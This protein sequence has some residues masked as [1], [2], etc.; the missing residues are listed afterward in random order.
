MN[1][2]TTKADGGIRITLGPVASKLAVE[3]VGT[4]KVNKDNVDD[5]ITD[6]QAQSHGD[7][8]GPLAAKI[9][10]NYAGAEAVGWEHLELALNELLTE[11]SAPNV[12]NYTPLMDELAA[13][14]IQLRYMILASIAPTDEQQEASLEMGVRKSGERLF[15]TAGDAQIPVQN[16][17]RMEATIRQ[18][19]EDSI[20]M[21]KPKERESEPEVER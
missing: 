9:A 12:P 8:M 7:R 10:E 13:S 17:R 19:M 16:A 2:D 15:K 21:E 18:R 20:H 4:E 14:L 1:D 6:L 5:A 11:K 3:Y